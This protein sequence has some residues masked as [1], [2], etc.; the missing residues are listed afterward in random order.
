MILSRSRL[1]ANPWYSL[2]Y[3]YGYSDHYT[4]YTDV[5]TDKKHK[6]GYGKI[7]TET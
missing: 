7:K 2:G 1:P 6:T 4:T 5:E 3:E